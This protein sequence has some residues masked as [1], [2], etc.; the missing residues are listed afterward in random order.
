MPSTSAT[1]KC[2]LRHRHRLCLQLS[3]HSHLL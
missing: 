1:T 3:S 2:A